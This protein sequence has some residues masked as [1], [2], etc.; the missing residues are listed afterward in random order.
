[1][2]QGQSRDS[3]LTIVTARA[4]ISLRLSRHVLR[5]TRH[6]YFADIITMMGLLMPHTRP[7]RGDASPEAAFRA[8]S[9]FHAAAAPTAFRAS[10]AAIAPKGVLRADGGRAAPGECRRAP[11]A[12]A[13]RR[14]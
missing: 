14:R 11:H 12:A 2:H 1:M 6:D 3:F 9:L 4:I 10:T 7:L 5:T 13:A 8:I